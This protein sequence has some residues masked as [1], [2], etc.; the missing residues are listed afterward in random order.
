MIKINSLFGKTNGISN[1]AKGILYNTFVLYFVFFIALFN[2]LYAVVEGNYLH[3]VL[4][5]LIGFLTSF[6]NK[7]MIVILTIAIASATIISN[8]IVG[9]KM[10]LEEG[11]TNNVDP[12]DDENVSANLISSSTGNSDNRL[13][14][15]LI[16]KA[17]ID[18]STA[19]LD[20]ERNNSATKTT[21]NGNNKPNVTAKVTSGNTIAGNTSSQ[22]SSTLVATLQTQAIDLQDAQKNIIKGF[23]TISPY[24]DKA[25]NI[26]N[27]IQTTAQTIQQIKKQNTA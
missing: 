18:N 13:V 24:M 20:V 19:N 25:E 17:G 22:P 3:C 15:Q 1:V 7:N 9:K 11:L 21:E 27:S 26:I 5:V 10:K 6:F 4:F 16:N 14:G 23:E 12:A 2:L 8:I